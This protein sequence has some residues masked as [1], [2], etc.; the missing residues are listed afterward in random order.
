MEIRDITKDCARKSSLK[1]LPRIMNSH[2]KPLKAL[3]IVGLIVLF[4]ICVCQ[5]WVI[6]TDYF[7]YSAVVTVTESQLDLTKGN[8]QLPN[9]LVCNMNPLQSEVDQYEESSD[10]KKYYIEEDFMNVQEFLTELEQVTSC[11]NKSC[12]TREEFIMAYIKY[13]SSTFLNYF[14]HVGYRATTILSHQKENFIIHCKLHLDVGGLSCETDCEDA[15]LVGLVQL[16]SYLKIQYGMCT[17]ISFNYN[18]TVKITGISLTLHLDNFNDQF[19]KSE[20]FGINGNKGSGALVSLYEPGTYP[21]ITSASQIASS[22]M[23][24]QIGYQIKSTKILNKPYGTC[25]SGSVITM[26][27]HQFKYTEEV[28]RKHCIAAKV[29]T[30]C[31]C[32]FPDTSNDIFIGDLLESAEIGNNFCFYLKRNRSELIEKYNCLQN[33]FEANNLDNT[34]YESC[35]RPCEAHQYSMSVSAVKWPKKSQYKAIYENRIANKKYAW[36]YEALKKDCIKENCT[37]AE[38]WK[39]EQLIESNLAKA[40][41]FLEND[42]HITH[43]EKPKTT[44]SVLVSQLGATLNL[45]CG[46]TVVIF[47][48]LV[49]YF[50]LLFMKKSERKRNAVENEDM[51]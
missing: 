28:C 39:Q 10:N 51:H 44:F 42:R 35:P 24:T 2:E 19:R 48:E 4:G 13:T 3:W 46:I 31:G 15:G 47:V 37:L 11:Q 50:I 34:C 18:D 49:E 20:Y 5:V 40:N 33:V 21:M 16:K 26:F 9:I 45:W 1:G 38:E 27:K 25:D 17:T 43:E 14:S 41:I 23:A 6:L 7:E 36:R 22:G 32:V 30:A 12:N 29:Y 8:V